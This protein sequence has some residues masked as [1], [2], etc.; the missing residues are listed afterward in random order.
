VTRWQKTARATQATPIST[1]KEHKK[2]VIH[3]DS[4]AGIEI[5]EG[6]RPRRV[7]L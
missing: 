4:L 3:W 1:L 6:F 2:A 7:L 5:Y